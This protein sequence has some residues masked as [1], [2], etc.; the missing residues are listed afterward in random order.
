MRSK[1]CIKNEQNTNRCVPGRQSRMCYHE[2]GLVSNE[3]DIIMRISRNRINQTSIVNKSINQSVSHKIKY[4]GPHQSPIYI[5]RINLTNPII[6][7][8]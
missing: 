8:L 3:Q 1:A 6:S 5:A 7:E 2:T 4:V